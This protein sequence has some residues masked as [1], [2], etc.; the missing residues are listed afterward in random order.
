M[1]KILI[2][3]SMLI[4]LNTFSFTLREFYLSNTVSQ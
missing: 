4:A 2:G 1:K 3:V